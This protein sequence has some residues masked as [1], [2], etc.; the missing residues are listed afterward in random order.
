M[1]AKQPWRQFKKR[2]YAVNENTREKEI[3]SLI[4]MSCNR[5]RSE[6]K[7]PAGY[8]DKWDYVIMHIARRWSGSKR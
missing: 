6:D 4:L 8:S 7:A 1:K 5:I 3:E 2:I